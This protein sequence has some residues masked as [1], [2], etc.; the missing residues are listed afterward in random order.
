MP[1]LSLKYRFLKRLVK[2]IGLK[3]F[4]SKSETVKVKQR[5]FQKYESI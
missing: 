3:K 5:F 1:N 4:F 2:L